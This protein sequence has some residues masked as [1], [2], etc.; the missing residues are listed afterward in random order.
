MRDH[1][2]K[3]V[4]MIKHNYHFVC[5]DF[6]DLN[7]S[8][9]ECLLNYFV[10]ATKA[11]VCYSETI[12]IDSNNRQLFWHPHRFLGKTLCKRKLFPDRLPFFH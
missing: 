12:I 9:V 6:K 11:F 3:F 1:R 7:P 5:I 8:Q 10:E 2:Y 4:N